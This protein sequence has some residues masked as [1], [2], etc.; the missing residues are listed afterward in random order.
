MTLTQQRTI[1]AK[2][3]F[4]RKAREVKRSGR[5]HNRFSFMLMRGGKV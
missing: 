3:N 1:S 5:S 2:A 4:V